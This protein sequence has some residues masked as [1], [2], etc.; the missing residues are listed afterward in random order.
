MKLKYTLR[1]LR[2]EDLI[3]QLGLEYYD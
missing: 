1:F 2:G 3:T